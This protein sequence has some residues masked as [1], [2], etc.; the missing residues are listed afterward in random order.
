MK[1]CA[2]SCRYDWHTRK[3]YI[4]RITT[5]FTEMVEQRLE[6]NT[7]ISDFA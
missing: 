4:K 3:A 7:T 6:P 1:G 2:Y 5:E